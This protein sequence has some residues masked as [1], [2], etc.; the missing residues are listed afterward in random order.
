MANVLE[1]NETE[2]CKL[3]PTRRI[4][5]VGQ[6]W[7]NVAPDVGSSISIIAYG[8]A[9]CLARDW[10]V[11]VYGRRWPGQKHFEINSENI[12]FK[13]FTVADK[14]QRILITIFSVLSCW[15]KNASITCSPISIIFSTFYERR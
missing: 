4:A 1:G 10:R 14:H 8:L 2:A 6:P 7:E 15:K 12:E 9:R 13:R 3:S 5:I 11:T